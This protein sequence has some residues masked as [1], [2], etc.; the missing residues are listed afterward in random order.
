M[1]KI[2]AFPTHVL[3]DHTSGVDFARVIQPMKY[4]NGFEEFK[5]DIFDIH[6]PKQLNWLEIADRY[7]LV[8]LNYTVV[9][10]SFAAMG[11]CIRGKNKKMIMDL[12]DATWKVRHDNPTYSQ[13]MAN[14]AKFIHDLT[15][16]IDEVDHVT[17]TTRYLKNVIC[18]KSY[19]RHDQVTVI[20]NYIDLNL[21]KYHYPAKEKREITI[22]HFGSTTHFEDLLQKPF[23]QGMKKL[24]DEFPNVRFMTVGA[25][26]P[27]YKYRF[28][29]RYTN[30][31]GHEDIYSW[32]ITRF[33]YFMEQT[34]IV[35]SPLEIDVYNRSKSA[36]KFLEYSSAGKPGVYQDIDQ[37]QDVV[38]HGVNGF[39]ASKSEDWYNYLKQLV[40]DVQLR[41][42]IG[43][44][45]FKTTLQ[46]QI[47][48][49]VSKYAEL[50]RKIL[51]K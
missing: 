33:P 32:I 10:W 45:A 8:F 25:N 15:C 42:K 31:F 49:H 21:Y 28:S 12:D 43:K 50:F 34:D 46:Y 38:R 9:D 48:D 2:F 13:F 22:T 30:E 16:M 23:Y 18:D 39:L 44:E 27:E 29:E 37:Y 17:T 36:I 5:V 47:K 35:V 26:I 20:P 40:L 1:I 11:V 3:K 4:L 51:D 41:R 7:D 19:K 24:M 14:N 6:A